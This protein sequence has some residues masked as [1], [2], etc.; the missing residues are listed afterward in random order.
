MNPK[1][2][3]LKRF[4]I[5]FTATSRTEEP[6]SYLDYPDVSSMVHKYL[7]ENTV[8]AIPRTHDSLPVTA[9]SDETFL[10]NTTI[11]QTVIPEGVEMIY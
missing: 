10:N 5:Q 3:K 9:I 2:K 4:F 11:E 1:M 8:V 7:G 6:F